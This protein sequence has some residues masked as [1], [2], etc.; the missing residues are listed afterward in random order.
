MELKIENIYRYCHF[1]LKELCEFI[2]LPS[3]FDSL[4]FS[5]SYCLSFQGKS[6]FD[7]LK[8]IIMFHNLEDVWFVDL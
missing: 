5:T 7:T 2:F 1:F 6:N 3:M 8:K 4:Y